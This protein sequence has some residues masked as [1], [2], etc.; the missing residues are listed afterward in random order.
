MKTTIKQ[1]PI[2]H[3]DKAV[4][5]HDIEAPRTDHSDS[6][7]FQDDSMK[8]CEEILRRYEAPLRLDGWLHSGSNKRAE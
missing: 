4:P 8:F 7:A 2:I 1:K 6:Q 5:S 3:L